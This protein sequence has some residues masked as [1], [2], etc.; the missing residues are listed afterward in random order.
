MQRT[1]RHRSLIRGESLESTGSN[2][3]SLADTDGRLAEHI[4]RCSDC[5]THAIALLSAGSLGSLTGA[6]LPPSIPDFNLDFL[7]HRAGINPGDGTDSGANNEPEDAIIGSPRSFGWVV[8]L[9]LISLAVLLVASLL[10]LFNT[11]NESSTRD[12][13][14]AL[15]NT[16]GLVGPD[17]EEIA[18][19]W[20]ETSPPALPETPTQIA[21]KSGAPLASRE[22]VYRSKS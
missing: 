11:L 3:D 8:P 12:E 14:L 13:N 18:S 1:L 4:E 10:P 5:Q 20:D 19:E 7:G 22:P 21:R 15:E 17:D 16:L 9:L 6:E 2:E